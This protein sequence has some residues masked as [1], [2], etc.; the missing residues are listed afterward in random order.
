M[1]YELTVH[2]NLDSIKPIL[3]KNLGWSSAFLNG[4]V[5]EYAKFLQL[6]VEYQNEDFV[7]G[8]L[9]DIVWREH[10]LHTKEYVELCD[11]IF[12][13][14]FH[15][16]TKH[17]DTS[18][19]NYDNIFSRTVELYT[20]QF[21]Y[22]PSNFF[23][24]KDEVWSLNQI[25]PSNNIYNKNDE[26]N[27]SQIA[28]SSYSISPSAPSYP[29]LEDENDGEIKDETEAKKKD[30]KCDGPRGPSVH[31]I[32]PTGYKSCTKKKSCSYNKVLTRMMNDKDI[33][34]I[35]KLMEN[36]E[37]IYY[38]YRDANGF[39]NIVDNINMIPRGVAYS[40]IDKNEKAGKDI[41]FSYEI[42]NK[43]C[44]VENKKSIPKGVNYQI[45]IIDRGQEIIG[46]DNVIDN[47]KNMLNNFDKNMLYGVV[48]GLAVG[49]M[50]IGIGAWSARN[51]K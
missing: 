20:V 44:N 30:G 19:D 12:F 39:L 4:L 16:Q 51:N 27:T 11:E 31:I 40:F 47:L 33:E 13:K 22:P 15:R 34:G 24:T 37:E 36:G 6:H 23:W 17:F 35:S 38:I 29:D 2:S 41:Y 10:I 32:G 26:L 3:Q 21:G 42:G 48:S 5:S 25:I 46:E 14:Y 45:M 49:S 9:I 8:R 28:S 43:I 7:P 1:N 18:N 50:F